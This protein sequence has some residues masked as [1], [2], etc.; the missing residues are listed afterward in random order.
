MRG[1]WVSSTVDCNTLE[2]TWTCGNLTWTC[3]NG[4][5][6]NAAYDEEHEDFSCDGPHFTGPT[7]QV[8]HSIVVWHRLWVACPA[9]FSV[10]ARS[11]ALCRAC[12]SV[13][14]D[15]EC[16]AGLP[17]QRG[18][19]CLDSRCR[20]TGRLGEP[21]DLWTQCLSGICRDSKCDGFE[22]TNEGDTR[23]CR[24]SPPPPAACE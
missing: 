2:L 1:G 18:L 8:G 10:R 14:L 6:A 3:G 24:P 20:R 17:C 12:S 11:S 22:C 13:A 15:A 21:C 4:E 23:T 7:D 19:D 9:V 5:F 16:A